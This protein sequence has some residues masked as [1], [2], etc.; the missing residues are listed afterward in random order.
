M[1]Q[2][3]ALLSAG[4]QVVGGAI[5]YQGA[6]SAAAD[7]V[8]LANYEATMGERLA[9]FE[10]KQLKQKAREEEG[11]AALR[12]RERLHDQE[13][14]QSTVQARAAASGGGASN[15]TVL[16]LM[17]DIEKRGSFLAGTEITAGRRA[18]SSLRNQAAATILQ[19][20][21]ASPLIR[22]RGAA[23]AAGQRLAGTGALI[24]GIGGA[25]GTVGSAYARY[26]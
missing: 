21:M 17:T 5:Q 11:A 25:A 13:L 15:P 6:Q 1:A 14:V 9:E 18:A 4:T 19:A 2:M 16:D 12:A 22:A 7:S 23:T 24:G 20:Q 8:A 26:R 10:S 3:M